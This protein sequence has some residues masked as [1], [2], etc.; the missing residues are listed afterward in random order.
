MAAVCLIARDTQ[1]RN[2]T[3][4]H[5]DWGASQFF[6][7]TFHAGAVGYFYNPAHRRQQWIEGSIS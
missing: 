6:S 3:S 7:P 4:A 2:G 5:L 1:Y